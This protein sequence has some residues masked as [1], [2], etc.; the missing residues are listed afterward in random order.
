MRWPPAQPIACAH[1]GMREQHA[2][3]CPAAV[4]DIHERAVEAT[5]YGVYSRPSTGGVASPRTGWRRN[6]EL[7]HRLHDLQAHAAATEEQN[8]QLEEQ[9]GR[10]E[11]FVDALKREISRLHEDAERREKMAREAERRAQ[12][13]IDQALRDARAREDELRS[14]I[15]ALE[16]KVREARSEALSSRSGGARSARARVPR[17]P[18]GAPPTTPTH[19]SSGHRIAVETPSATE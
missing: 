14:R 8:G 3:T 9:N 17:R 13:A 7:E 1:C 4:D 10:L 18:K 15:S 16:Q 6:Q 2:D 11:A 19:D 12:E 5:P